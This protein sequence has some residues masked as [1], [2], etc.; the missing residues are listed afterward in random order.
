[1]LAPVPTDGS[2]PR[3]GRTSLLRGHSAGPTAGHARQGITRGSRILAPCFSAVR[4]AAVYMH[5]TDA[6]TAATKAGP[7]ARTAP[8]AAEHP[9]KTTA[10]VCIPGSLRSSASNL[11]LIWAC[12]AFDLGMRCSRLTQ[13]GVSYREKSR[14]GLD[15]SCDKSGVRGDSSDAASY[16]FD[17]EIV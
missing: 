10:W 9:R 12:E 6:G 13:G 2:T 5:G 8:A 16:G 3:L 14:E 4:Y 17:A 7:R 11:S 15:K 1:M